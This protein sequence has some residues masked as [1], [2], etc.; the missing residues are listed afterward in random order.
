MG[1]GVGR[2]RIIMDGNGEGETMERE[3]LVE[4]RKFTV[5]G[6]GCGKIMEGKREE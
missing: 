6:D 2:G 4:G 3:E 5:R 1:G